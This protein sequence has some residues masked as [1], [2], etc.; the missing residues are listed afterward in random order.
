MS[1]P[2]ACPELARPARGVVIGV[3]PG[4][5][6][7]VA[8]FSRG[9]EL[10]EVHPMPLDADGVADTLELL[11]LFDRDPALVAVEKVNAHPTWGRPSIWTFARNVQAVLSA[12]AVGEFRL[13]DRVLPAAWKKV[14]LAGT[15]K[16]KAAAI[17]HAHK[18]YPDFRAAIGKHDGMADAVCIGEYACRVLLPRLAPAPPP[19]PELP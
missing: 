13:D 8:I 3:D 15:E 14:V 9:G 19:S 7:G 16:D 6:G 17:A 2:G 10:L 1:S 12:C 18:R 5:K 11:L 4:A